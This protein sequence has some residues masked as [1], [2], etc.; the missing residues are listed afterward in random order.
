MD[1]D[2]VATTGP[3]THAQRWTELARQIIENEG[4]DSFDSL[5]TH[6]FVQESRRVDHFGSAGRTCSRC[7]TR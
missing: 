7:T 5:L 3:P 2:R 1:E 4:R 6:N